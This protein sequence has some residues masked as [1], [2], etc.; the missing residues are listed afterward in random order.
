MAEPVTV[1][2]PALG[3]PRILRQNWCDL[4]FLHWAVDRA[5]IAHYFPPGTTPDTFEGRTYVGLVPFRMVGT[6]LPRGPAIPWLG[7]FLETNIRLYSVDATG[8]R[9]VVFLSLDADRAA[10]VAAARTTFGLPYRWARMRH[11]QQGDQ[12]TYTSALRW[13]GTRATSTIGIQAGDRLEPGPLEHFLTARWGLHVGRAGR[14]WYLP[15]EHPA[16][17]L[18]AAELT[19]FEE[20]GL[21]A[22]VGLG[23]LS[24]RPPDH[25]AFSDGVPAKFGLPRLASR[26]RGPASP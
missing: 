6:G 22:S 9:G 5:S 23:E 21:L 8:R 16:W 11:R 13:P 2:A 14:T 15:N 24:G 26:P 19:A 12:H 17:V 18:R 3:R 1:E 25:L 20:H 10:V 4:A 7:T